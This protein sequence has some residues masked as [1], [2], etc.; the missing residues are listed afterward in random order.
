MKTA[1]FISGRLTCYEEDLIKVLNTTFYYNDIDLFISINGIRDEYHIEAEERL[2]KWLRKIDYEEY[3]VPESFINT[4]PETLTQNIN[5]KKTP[6]TVMSMFYNDQKNFKNI[7]EYSKENNITYDIVCKF[8]A[9]ISFINPFIEFL[10]ERFTHHDNTLFSCIP[11]CPI[12]L[13][14][15]IKLGGPLCISDAFAFGSMEV[16][17]RYCSTYD[18]IFIMNNKDNGYCRLNYETTLSVCFWGEESFSEY[19]EDIID[20]LYNAVAKCPYKIEYFN[21]LYNINDKRRERDM[22]KNLTANI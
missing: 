17:K 9:D 19:T 21:L 18:S 5:G 20:K 1:L 6:Y 14:S 2:Y 10:F 15:H 8:R 3:N 4:H 22:V 7:E 11:P 13:Y 16:M 12:I